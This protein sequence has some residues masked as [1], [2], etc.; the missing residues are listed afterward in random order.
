MFQARD[1]ERVRELVVFIHQ[2]VC[3]GQ[4]FEF[5]RRLALVRGALETHAAGGRHRV[6]QAPAGTGQRAVDLA[7]EH[8]VE[9]LARFGF[10][11]AEQG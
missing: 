2:C 7:F 6:E 8:A 5:D 3:V 4:R 10:E 9:Q 1:A 11:L